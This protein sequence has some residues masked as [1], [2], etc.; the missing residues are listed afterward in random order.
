[1]K[2]GDKYFGEGSIVNVILNTIYSRDVSSL[3]SS[4]VVLLGTS[5]YSMYLDYI[6][7]NVVYGCTASKINKC[8]IKVKNDVEWWIEPIYEKPSIVD[9]V[10]LNAKEVREA[11]ISSLEKSDE[12]D[13]GL[14]YLQLECKFDRWCKEQGRD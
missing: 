5:T 13:E 14:E 3:N 9:K 8:R 2:Y 1:M 11:N 7:D 10:M 12:I 4:N 6:R